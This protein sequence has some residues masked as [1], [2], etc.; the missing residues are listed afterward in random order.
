MI[1]SQYSGQKR[2][3]LFS[4]GSAAAD[5]SEALVNVEFSVCHFVSP[6][7]SGGSSAELRYHFD[8]PAVGD[9]RNRLAQ[10]ACASMV[11]HASILRVMNYRFP[12]HMHNLH[13]KQR[14]YDMVK[15][16][17]PLL[18]PLSA[19]TKQ[20]V[21]SYIEYFLEMVPQDF[22]YTE[23][24]LGNL[25]LAGG[26]LS[27]GREFDPVLRE[28]GP[29]LGCLGK[30]YL[31]TNEDFHLVAHLQGGD[32]VVGQHLFTGKEV[33][34]LNRRI[35]RLTLSKSATQNHPVQSFL[36][37]KRRSLITSA[38][39]ICYPPGSFFSSLI[40][41]LLPSGSA[42]AIADAQVAKVFLP[43]LGDDPESFQVNLN[44]QLDT[45]FYHLKS[46][47]SGQPTL[48]NFLTHVV[49]DRQLIVNYPKQCEQL[50]K[51][52]QKE[53]VELLFTSSLN[54]MVAGQYDA[55]EVADLLNVLV[56]QRT[57]REDAKLLG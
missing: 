52:A 10:L 54:S 41:N 21:A 38:D 57:Q 46:Q 42:R 24:C 23:A 36:S 45:L 9:L 33:A 31:T 1:T 39:L 15:A 32:I 7:D 3:I 14:L 16:D 6:Y 20:L 17:D 40:A 47:L 18:F 12:E 50:T 26:Y 4:G 25:I 13:I 44:A 34:P 53:G 11:R 27:H 43:N 8:M 49:V 35:Q 48:R 28:L 55:E 5:L 30:V 22:Q 29:A 51:Y 56:A 2:I 37:A 19:S